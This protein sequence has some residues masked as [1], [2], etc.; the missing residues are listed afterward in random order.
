MSSKARSIEIY[1]FL[2]CSVQALYLS[3]YTQI[4]PIYIAYLCLLP[5]LAFS[6]ATKLNKGKFQLDVWIIV[7]LLLTLLVM[8]SLSI[9]SGEY[10]N[11]FFGGISYLF[12]RVNCWS[13]GIDQQV[14]MY[15]KG[16]WFSAILL[17]IDS[18]YRIIFPET[19]D[20]VDFQYMYNS[21]R[22]FYVYKYNSIMFSNSN[23]TALLALVFLCTLSFIDTKSSGGN[24]L[25]ILIFTLILFSTFSRAAMIGWLVAIIF[26]YIKR[27]F[28]PIAS[29]FSVMIGSAIASFYLLGLNDIASDLSLQS[30]YLIV[31]RVMMSLASANAIDLLFGFGLGSSS[32][33]LGLHAHALIFSY[34]IEGGLLLTFLFLAFI[35]YYCMK[36]NLEILLPTIVV[37]MSSYLYLGAPFLFISMALV[38]NL[39]AYQRKFR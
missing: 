1:F 23:T 5:G 11:L 2:V 28:G 25:L 15:K 21:D 4:S 14:S 36:I 3:K 16:L 37:S 34:L 6:I 7:A 22:W 17:A 39:V 19:P 30:K 9:V 27:N 24:K 33:L 32:D 20:A 8:H 18:T 38:A 12:I 29:G 10:L 26:P 31:D 35:F 13:I